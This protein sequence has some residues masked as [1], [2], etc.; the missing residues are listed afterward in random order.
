MVPVLSNAVM[1]CVVLGAFAVFGARWAVAVAWACTLLMP[2]W[3][4]FQIGAIQVQPQTFSALLAVVILCL[5]SKPR[6]FWLWTDLLCVALAAEQVASDYSNGEFTPTMTASAGLE[7]VLPYVFGRL[8]LQSSDDL[9]RL[10]RS[11]AWACVILSVWTIVES[12]TR[13]N[14]VASL[15]KHV[16]SDQ[17]AFDIR[18]GLRRAEGSTVHPIFLGMLLVLLL[19]W[20]LVAAERA[21]SGFGP[22]WWKTLPWLVGTAVFLTIS[23]GPQLALLTMLAIVFFCRFP[24]WRRILAVT[25]VIAV[26]SVV[27]G[28]SFLV[29]VLHVWSNEKQSQK[30]QVSIHGELYEYS[31]TNHRLLQLKVYEKSVALAGWFGFGGGRLSGLP[32][33]LP[34]LEHHL[35]EQFNSID[36]HYLMWVLRS[37][38]FGLGAFLVFSVVSLIRLAPTALST[39][40]EYSM[41]AASL[42]GAIAGVLVMLATVYFAPDFGYIWLFAVGL[43]SSVRS[44]ADAAGSAVPGTISISPAMAPRR[45]ATRRLT[46]GHPV[47]PHPA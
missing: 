30:I 13:V 20:A 24:A 26:V 40:G 3:L 5:E 19:P 12:I 2:T 17:A 31:G 10:T 23:R 36:C 25:A 22:R 37:G 21:K 18:W 29:D 32:R 35:I 44:C 6:G 27:G 16:S 45:R 1:I 42:F 11:S 28:R 8:A 39:T 15:F 9:N 4:D 14:V 47:L 7:W 46:P 43:G 41:L 33:D 38:Y 34:G